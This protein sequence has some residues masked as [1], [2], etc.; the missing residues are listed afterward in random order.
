MQYLTVRY[1][2]NATSHSNE[3]DDILLV[4]PVQKFIN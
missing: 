4:P 3:S 2:F 1:R